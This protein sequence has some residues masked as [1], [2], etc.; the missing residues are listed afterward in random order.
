MST[1][2]EQLRQGK[3]SRGVA[4]NEPA[5]VTGGCSVLPVKEKTLGRRQDTQHK[6]DEGLAT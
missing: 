2:A 3:G 4:A 6:T 1:G 5:V